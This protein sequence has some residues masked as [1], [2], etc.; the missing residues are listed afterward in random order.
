M[1]AELVKSF[2]FDAAHALSSLPEGHK[3]SRLHGH[4][5]R[6][7]VHIEGVVD[8]RTGWLMDFADIAAA[9]DPVIAQLDHRVLNEVPQLEHST[10]EGL[11]RYIWERISAALPG[12]SAVAVWES[13]NSRCVYRGR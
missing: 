2:H 8:P 1:R 6:V 7:D 12:L 9:V 10:S 5:Y 11:A 13:P 3:C 4:G